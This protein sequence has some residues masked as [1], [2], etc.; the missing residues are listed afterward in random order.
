MS[1]SMSGSRPSPAKI[2]IFASPPVDRHGAIH[3]YRA[4]KII[5]ATGYYDLANQ[6]E[7][8]GEDLEKSLSLLPRA[9]SV[10]R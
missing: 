10:F 1:A 2:R 3:D 8:P 9:S 5:L 4:R 7:I 6:L